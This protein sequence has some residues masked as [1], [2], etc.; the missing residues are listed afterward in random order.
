MLWG[1]IA[2]PPPSP[3]HHIPFPSKLAHTKCK[4]TG[5]MY[6]CPRVG[7]QLKLQRGFFV[8]EAGYLVPGSRIGRREHCRGFETPGFSLYLLHW[9]GSSLQTCSRLIIPESTTNKRSGCCCWYPEPG[10]G[11]AVIAAQDLLPAK[12]EEEGSFYFPP[13]AP[14]WNHTAL[15]DIGRDEAATGVTGGLGWR[16]HSGPRRPCGPATRAQKRPLYKR[17]QI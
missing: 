5:W 6:F 1:W 15:K 3:R 17:Y 10:T 12:H 16:E 11:G 13:P 14:C 9:P 2:L 7:L 4:V 8:L